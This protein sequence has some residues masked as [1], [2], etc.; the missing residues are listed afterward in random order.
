M[1]YCMLHS[2]VAT[3]VDGYLHP[4]LMRSQWLQGEV[5][6]IILVIVGKIVYRSVP[7]H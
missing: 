7:S 4:L 5:I 3:F 2:N 6:F 1:A